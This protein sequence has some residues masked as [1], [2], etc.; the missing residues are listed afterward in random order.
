MASALLRL[1]A[2]FVLLAALLFVGLWP[3]SMS[4]PI[5]AALTPASKVAAAK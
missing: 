1:V 5:N 3:K 4:D 2:A